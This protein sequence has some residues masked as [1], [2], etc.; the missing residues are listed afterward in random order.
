M[1][2]ESYDCCEI[3]MVNG[4]SW[5]SFDEHFGSRFA[6]KQSWG[7]TTMPLGKPPLSGWANG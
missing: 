6:R 2:S 4:S 1:V 7:W 5:S 3:H